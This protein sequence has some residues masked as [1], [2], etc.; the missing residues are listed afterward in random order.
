M[1]DTFATVAASAALRET[2]R[3]A[4]DL[5]VQQLPTVTRLTPVPLETSGEPPVDEWLAEHAVVGTFVGAASY[6]V[7]LAVRP[8]LLPTSGDGDGVLIDYVR[9][10]LGDAMGRFGSGV[11]TGLRVDD[12][13]G[14]FAQPDAVLVRLDDAGAPAGAFAVLQTSSPGGS[15]DVLERLSRISGVE[16]DLTVQIGRTR[17]AV[18]DVLGL[19][20]GSIVELD[21]SAGA[22][23]DILLNG[24]LIAH[25]EVVVVD[26]DY[27]VRITAIVDA[28]SRT[29]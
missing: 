13:R 16:M 6:R 21:R 29:L 15:G 1:T 7:A 19:E 10:A 24:R 8:E 2:A 22:P 5:L 23:A 9:T 28:P 17:L 14:L 11:L 25:G 12:A 20:P 3:A 26:Q 4:A 27:A 18:R